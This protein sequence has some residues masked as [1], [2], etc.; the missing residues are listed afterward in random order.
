MLAKTLLCLLEKFGFMGYQL[1]RSTWRLLYA[2]DLLASGRRVGKLTSHRIPFGWN[3]F[4]KHNT[5]VKLLLPFRQ[6]L[7]YP[8][9]LSKDQGEA[10]NA[11]LINLRRKRRYCF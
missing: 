2:V 7:K 1:W 3:R 10:H 4:P 11:A 6:Q 5:S 8:R 9:K